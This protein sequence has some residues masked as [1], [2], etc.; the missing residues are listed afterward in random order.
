[1]DMK[2]LFEKFEQKMTS[3]NRSRYISKEIKKRVSFLKMYG[4][5]IK[6]LSETQKDEVRK[7]YKN[8]VKDFSTYE[9]IYSIKGEFNPYIFPEKLHFSKFDL[10]LNDK[11][12][13]H[14]WSDKNYANKF[15]PQV[16]FPVAIVRNIHGNYYDAEY[17]LITREE[18]IEKVSK[19]SK[20]CIKPSVGCSGQGVS[21]VDVEQSLENE[22][23]NR[24]SNYIVQE[25]L[26]QYEPLKRLNP[27]SVNIVRICS[28]FLNGRVSVVSATLRCGAVGAFNDNSITAD[29]K[30]MFVVKVDLQDGKLSDVGYYS[31]GVSLDKAPNGE[32]FA[33]IQ[34]PNF[35]KALKIVTDMHSQMPFAT[36]VGFD[37]AFDIN[38]EPTVMEYNLTA[39]GVFYYQLVSGPIFG[40]RTQEILDKY[41]NN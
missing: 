17:R 7:V 10:I 21:L 25:V 36:F 34:L 41:Y 37:M 26:E 12:T 38:G 13:C 11:K 4:I 27:T 16:K 1:M 22:F 20:V 31:C 23:K 35:E 6:K 5:P 9:L 39:P 14:V 29:G 19:Y 33:G 40:N 3:L 32:M 18:A 28:V 2:R 24:K 30:G 8:K 15:F